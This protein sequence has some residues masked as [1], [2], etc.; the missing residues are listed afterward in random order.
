MVVIFILAACL[1][2][3]FAVR[4][5]VNIL[6]RGGETALHNVLERKQEAGKHSSRKL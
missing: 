4:F 5:V 6:F 3:T 2:A 1:A